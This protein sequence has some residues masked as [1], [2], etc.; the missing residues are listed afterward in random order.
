MRLPNGYGSVY[1]LSGKRRK[2][3]AVRKTVGFTKDNKQIYKIIGYF[4]TKKEGLQAL[5]E[6]NANPYDIANNLTFKEIYNRWFQEKFDENSNPST[7]RGYKIAYKH[8]EKLHNQ[9]FNHLRLKD[10]QPIVSHQK[11]ASGLRVKILLNNMYKWCLKYDYSQKNY[12]QFIE[13]DTSRQTKEKRAISQKHIAL[14][15]KELQNNEHIAIILM[16]IYSGVRINE[17][18]N[19]KKDDVN[20]NKQYFKIK[21]S[22]T[23]SGVRTVPIANKTLSFWEKAMNNKTEYIIETPSG[24]KMNYENFKKSY[25]QVTMRKL[26][27]DYM[28]HETR[29]TC[30]TLL[31]IANVNPTIRKKIIG[32]KRNMDIGEA[33]YTHIPVEKLVE[34]I[35]LI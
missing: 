33:L 16:L 25:W 22:K 3:Y 23:K 1:K 20:I 8:C 28:I 11:A 14:L 15:W 32:H 17:L 34:T 31:V 21:E 24:L 13:V 19:L 29:H 2:P 35:N 18:L 30:N 5:A 27:L 26:N 10:L 6:Y 9:L 7:V 4:K 12:A